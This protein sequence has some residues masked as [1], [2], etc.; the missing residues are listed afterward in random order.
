MTINWPTAFVVV[1]AIAA[2][3]SLA[4]TGTE[5]PSWLAGV[6]T[7]LGTAIG[8]MFPK[9]FGLGGEK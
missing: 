4:I 1:I 3:T 8:A 9:L 2:G 5:V 7:I 6:F